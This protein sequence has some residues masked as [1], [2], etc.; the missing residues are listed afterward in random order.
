MT[1]YYQVG[2]VELHY[3]LLLVLRQEPMTGHQAYFKVKRL[4]S[5]LFPN[6]PASVYNALKSMVE[7]SL[8]SRQDDGSYQITDLG[9]QVARDQSQVLLT[10]NRAVRQATSP[11]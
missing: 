1:K 8:V 10:I 4:T 5:D 11:T 6:S 2:L 7:N 3:L 9:V